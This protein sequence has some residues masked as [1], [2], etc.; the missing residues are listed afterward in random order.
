MGSTDLL[1]LGAGAFTA[2]VLGIVVLVASLL[3]EGGG[4]PAAGR[5][6]DTPVVFCGTCGRPVEVKAGSPTGWT[7][8][9][10]WQG[11]RCPGVLTGA[12]PGPSG[13]LAGYW[14]MLDRQDEARR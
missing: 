7:H 3:P 12:V 11:V 2:V 8:W 4:G 1:L 13:T 9:G 6:E 5:P 14:A 10:M